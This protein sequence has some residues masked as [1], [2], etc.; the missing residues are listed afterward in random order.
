MNGDV[1]AEGWEEGEVTSMIY[2]KTLASQNLKQPQVTLLMAIDDLSVA[3]FNDVCLVLTRLKSGK[4]FSLWIF[5]PC[6]FLEFHP[7]PY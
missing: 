4:H 1:R 6:I 7:L 5:P 2:L 3:K